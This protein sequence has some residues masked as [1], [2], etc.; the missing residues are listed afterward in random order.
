MWQIWS[1][2]KYKSIEHRA[3]TNDTSARLSY[4]SFVT[5]AEDV[6][7]EPLPHMVDSQGFLQMY[8]KV[9]YGE[10]MRE[11]I[12]RKLEGKAHIEMAKIGS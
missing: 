9:I 3:V 1:N 2:G 12:K 4:A 11:S 7:V 10:Y 6:E 8:K 5:P